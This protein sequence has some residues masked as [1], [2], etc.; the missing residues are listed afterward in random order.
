MLAYDSNAVSSHL[1]GVSRLGAHCA[2][3]TGGPLHHPAHGR[4]A[5]SAR[6]V[7]GPVRSS[8]RYHLSFSR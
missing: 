5:R 3:I 7:P 2:F 4:G 1:A 6:L 8:N